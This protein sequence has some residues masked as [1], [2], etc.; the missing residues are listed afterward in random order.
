MTLAIIPLLPLE[1]AYVKVLRLRAGIRAALLMV[2]AIGA[3]TLA[4]LLEQP[5]YGIVVGPALL[6]ALWMLVLAPPRRWKHMGYAYTGRELHVAAGYIFRSHT[7]VPVSRVQHIDIVQG[8]IERH[9]ELATL[10]LNTA[11]TDASAVLLPGIQRD[12]AEQI[13]DSIR[14]QIGSAAA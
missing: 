1:P 4:W 3:E 2:L 12:T 8:P 10:V 13:R 14:A 6:L 11:G 7:I 9:F 5:L